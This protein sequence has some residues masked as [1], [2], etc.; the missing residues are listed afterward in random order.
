MSID[1]NRMVG[2]KYIDQHNVKYH[3]Q[4]HGVLT[5]VLQKYNT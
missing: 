3:F 4:C 5:V 1:I 2:T